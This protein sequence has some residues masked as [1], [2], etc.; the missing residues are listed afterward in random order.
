MPFTTTRVGLYASADYI[1][2]NGIPQTS[3]DFANHCFVGFDNLNS[4]PPF[5]LNIW[6]Q[7][8]IPEKNV[9]LRSTDVLVL[10]HAILS[11]IGIGFYPA[12]KAKQRPNLIEIS[13][14][15]DQWDV[16]FWLITHA[17]LHRTAK[18]QAFLT[19]LQEEVNKP[20]S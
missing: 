17:D 15:Q 10:D 16:P 20:A 13:P 11:G 5:N 14:H 19:F 1:S 4:G 8:N 9:V 7:E 18:V 3:E 2:R 12:E 6:M